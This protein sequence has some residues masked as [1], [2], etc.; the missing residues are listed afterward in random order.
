MANLSELYYNQIMLAC[1]YFFE[2]TITAQESCPWAVTYMI[3]G[4]MMSSFI[5]YREAVLPQPIYKYILTRIL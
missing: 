2:K 1:Q 4:N 5:V 3:R